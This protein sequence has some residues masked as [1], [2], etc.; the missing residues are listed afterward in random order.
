MRKADAGNGRASMY[1]AEKS[2]LEVMEKM[3]IGIAYSV[4]SV[5]TKKSGTEPASWPQA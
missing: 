5:Y 4:K 3:K 2:I 1:G